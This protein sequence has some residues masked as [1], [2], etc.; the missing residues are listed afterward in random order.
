MDDPSEMQHA[1]FRAASSSVA[2]AMLLESLDQ[3]LVDVAALSWTLKS[4]SES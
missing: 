1:T 2:P 3:A 4:P